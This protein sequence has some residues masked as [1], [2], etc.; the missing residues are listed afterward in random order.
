MI[1]LVVSPDVV[2]VVKV[3]DLLRLFLPASREIYTY[4]AVRNNNLAL[5][6]RQCSAIDEDGKLKINASVSFFGVLTKRT[7][8]WGIPVHLV[9]AG[10]SSAVDSDLAALSLVRESTL[11]QIPRCS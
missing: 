9:P 11:H 1:A 7:I 5:T 3:V 4:L 6:V 8:P 2:S 10:D